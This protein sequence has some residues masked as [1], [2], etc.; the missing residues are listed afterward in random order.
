MGDYQ[1]NESGRSGSISFTLRSAAD[2]AFGEVVM[3]PAG[4]GHALVPWRQTGVGGAVSAT[5]TVLTIRFVRV[6]GGHVTGTLDP[7]A[8][9]RTGERLL[10][11]FDG[12]LGKDRNTIA[13]TF[14]TVLESGNKQPGRWTVQRRR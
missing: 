7:Y 1:G 14:T 5:Q 12:Q 6:E 11:T 10:T 9:P 13:G 8:D 4:F 2:S 3:I